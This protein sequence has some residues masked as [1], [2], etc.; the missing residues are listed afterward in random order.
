MASRIGKSG[1][2][3]SMAM[4]AFEI[5]KTSKKGKKRRVNL[6]KQL[7]SLEVLDDEETRAALDGDDAPIPGMR[8]VARRA[9]RCPANTASKGGLSVDGMLQMLSSRAGATIEQLHSHRTSINLREMRPPPPGSTLPRTFVAPGKHSWPTP[10]RSEDAKRREQSRAHGR[11]VRRFTKRDRFSQ[12]EKV[13]RAR[14]SSK[15]VAV[16]VFVTTPCKKKSV[17][18]DNRH[19]ERRRRVKLHRK[20]THAINFHAAA[21]VMKKRGTSPTCATIAPVLR[22]LFA[23]R[24]RS[25]YITRTDAPHRHQ[26]RARRWIRQTAHQPTRHR[27]RVVF[28]AC[29]GVLAARTRTPFCA[30]DSRGRTDRVLDVVRLPR[31]HHAIRAVKQ[32]NHRDPRRGDDARVVVG[33]LDGHGRFERGG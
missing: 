27:R 16:E 3:Q 15:D 26:R 25:A 24:P 11:H 9:R 31:P 1:S 18:S 32:R 33:N 17:R 22:P 7:I 5:T 12:G 14:P 8:E 2:S 19:I 4:D 10:P 28:P 20:H 6:R 13:E 21:N 30:D 29:F 23:L